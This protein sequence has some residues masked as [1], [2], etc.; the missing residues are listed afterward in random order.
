MQ[1]ELDEELEK[2][3]IDDKPE[4]VGIISEDVTDVGKV[5]LGAVFR[6]LTRTPD[7]YLPGEELSQF[8]WY[9]SDSLHRLNLE[10]WST[11]TLSLIRVSQR[12]VS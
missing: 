10:L 5:H 11:L 3:P 12:S 7:R 6:I 8:S 4:F 2:M 1:R 9:D